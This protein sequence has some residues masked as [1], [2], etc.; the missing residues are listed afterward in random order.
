MLYLI[1]PTLQENDVSTV[2]RIAQPFVQPARIGRGHNLI[3]L[4]FSPLLND[5]SLRIQDLVGELKTFC[6]L[7]IFGTSKSHVQQV[8]TKMSCY[9]DEVT[10]DKAETTKLF[11]KGCRADMLR[12]TTWCSCTLRTTNTLRVPRTDCFLQKPGFLETT[13]MNC[14]SYDLPKTNFRF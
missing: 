14:D 3:P 4:P 13:F 8:I 12:I 1:R 5:L 9:V 2:N 11:H 7:K 6:I 10:M